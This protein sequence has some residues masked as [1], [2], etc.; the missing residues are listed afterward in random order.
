MF[1]VANDELRSNQCPGIVI[2]LTGG[3]WYGQLKFKPPPLKGGGGGAV[4]ATG[5][6]SGGSHRDDDDPAKVELR[7]LLEVRASGDGGSGGGGKATPENAMTAEG[8][9]TGGV[10]HHLNL[11]HH[12]H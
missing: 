4:S 3:I 2:N 1:R 7:P 6:G 9:V 10:Q 8:A 5:P 12:R 11:G